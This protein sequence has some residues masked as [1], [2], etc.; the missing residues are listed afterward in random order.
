M[1][2][3]CR[4]F[5]CVGEQVGFIDL[6]EFVKQDS[7]HENLSTKWKA[8]NNASGPVAP[9]QLAFIVSKFLHDLERTNGK[10]SSFKKVVHL[11]SRLDDDLRVKVG[12]K[13]RMLDIFSSNDE[14]E[15]I[16][17]FRFIKSLHSLTNRTLKCIFLHRN[18]FYQI[19][20]RFEASVTKIYHTDRLTK[21]ELDEYLHQPISIDPREF[22]EECLGVCRRNR[23][24]QQ[25]LR[26]VTLRFP[27]AAEFID[28]PSENVGSALLRERT[29]R[30]IVTFLLRTRDNPSG[31][32]RGMDSEEVFRYF[33]PKVHRPQSA[34]G[35]SVLP[36]SERVGN[37]KAFLE[38]AL[39]FVGKSEK[40]PHETACRDLMSATLREERA[41]LAV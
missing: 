1:G 33:L 14:E 22:V 7:K 15:E 30:E 6:Q 26:D 28:V 23:L 21:Q 9:V 5:S 2:F 32:W 34:Q 17:L 25:Q 24:A 40:Y 31:E 8:E 19:L 29:M 20:S 41:R 37:A 38:G 35:R 4:S 13:I 11:F 36:L 12:F 3:F 27:S 10:N 16:K 39:A 18:P